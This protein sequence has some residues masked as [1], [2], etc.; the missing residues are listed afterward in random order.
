MKKMIASK[1]WLT[2]Y[3]IIL[4]FLSGL[5]AIGIALIIYSVCSNNTEALAIGIV[6]LVYMLPT[7]GIILFYFNRRACWI[8]V[9][10]GCFKWKGLFFGFRGSITPEEIDDIGCAK[11]QLYISVRC[12]K[13][14][15]HYREGIF[16]LSNT[17]ANRKLLKSFCSAEIYPPELCDTCKTI[18]LEGLKRQMRIWLHFCI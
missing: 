13:N 6:T 5:S 11:K 2:T 16:E 7:M 17:S 18:K 12:P 1:K 3:L 9:E 8:W 15:M 10:N 4:I 14:R